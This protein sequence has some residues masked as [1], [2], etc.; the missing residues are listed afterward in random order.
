MKLLCG[1]TGTR[2]QIYRNCDK[3]TY[4][5]GLEVVLKKH[6]LEKRYKRN[7]L[8]DLI[9]PEYDESIKHIHPNSSRTIRYSPFSRYFSIGLFSVLIAF[10]I[11]LI[12]IRANFDIVTLFYI[13]SIFGFIIQIRK[14]LVY[15]NE[16]VIDVDGIQFDGHQLL[17]RFI[18]GLYLYSENNDNDYNSQEIMIILHKSGK[19]FQV[20]TTM[21]SSTDWK[22]KRVINSFRHFG[23]YKKKSVYSK[24]SL[25]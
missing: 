2:P 7:T 1:L 20:D 10:A 24:P 9:D 4:D 15:N 19:E 16:I 6:L 8:T 14:S 21:L 3:H 18:A 13:A 12:V 23:Y 11:G 5:P 22:L 25:V 17:W